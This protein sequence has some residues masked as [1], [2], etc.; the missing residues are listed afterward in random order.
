M[1]IVMAHFRDIS[2]V[3]G[4]HER[5]LCNF[6][7]E[8]SKRG[9]DVHILTYDTSETGIPY[10]PL[11]KNVKVHN[12]RRKGKE[13][14]K[15]PF[16]KKISREWARSKGEPS[17]AAW[18]EAYRD[19]YILPDARKFFDEIH[20][21]VIIVY[22]YTTSGFVKETHGNIPVITMFHSIPDFLFPKMSTREF[23][24]ISESNVN[25]MLDPKLRTYDTKK[26]TGWK[27]R[28]YSKQRSSV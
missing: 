12:L 10:F 15:V 1:K 8:M 22:F 18:Y 11:E 21:D 13:P 27:H 14:I 3:S 4:G 25:S 5:V 9:H 20:P 28:L 24:G 26:N 23:Q 19:P 2:G 7:N 17:L 6:S 16:F